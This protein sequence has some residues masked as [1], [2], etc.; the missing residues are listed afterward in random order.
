LK[1]LA[2]YFFRVEEKAAQQRAVSDTRMGGT[3]TGGKN[4]SSKRSVNMYQTTRS[5]ISAEDSS[6][7]VTASETSGDTF[8]LFQREQ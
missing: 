1:D 2:A 4:I 6:F 3:R 5:Q 7:T 8:A